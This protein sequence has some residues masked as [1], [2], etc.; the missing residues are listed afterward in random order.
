[1]RH[2]CTIACGMVYDPLCPCWGHPT[3]VPYSP[4]GLAELLA[5]LRN[6]AYRNY[7][8]IALTGLLAPIIKELVK[9]AIDENETMRR[10]DALSLKAHLATVGVRIEKRDGKLVATPS[11]RITAEI[12]RTIAHYREIFLSEK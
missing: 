8:R 6:P 10:R 2:T 1:M 11:E 12:K 3:A 5:T 9:Q 4:T 7:L